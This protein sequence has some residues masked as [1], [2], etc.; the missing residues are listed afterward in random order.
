MKPSEF[1]VII[2]K[3]VKAVSFLIASRYQLTERMST[4][5]Y[6]TCERRWVP[7]AQEWR[8]PIRERRVTLDLFRFD[9]FLLRNLINLLRY[10]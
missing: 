4:V 2:W 8:A 6:G 7:A 5:L 1:R 9:A 10:Y 3:R